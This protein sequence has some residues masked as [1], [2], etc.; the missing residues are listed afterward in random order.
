ME[1]ERRA[2]RVREEGVRHGGKDLLVQQH[3]EELSQRATLVVHVRPAAAPLLLEHLPQ[4]EARPRGGDRV[5]GPWQIWRLDR[6]L[7]ALD[8]E[9]DAELQSR[10]E[11]LHRQYLVP[12]P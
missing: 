7:Q 11:A 10:L 4:P 1:V 12:A 3:S 2:L 9:I 5:A 6:A 8:F